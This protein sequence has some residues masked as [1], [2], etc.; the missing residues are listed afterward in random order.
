MN[1]LTSEQFSHQNITDIEQL[2]ISTQRVLSAK[3][4]YNTRRVSK[5]NITSLLTGSVIPK[6]G[7]LVLA[8]V[9][10]IGQHKR[11]ELTHGR[12]APLFVG[13]EII[14]CYG[15]RYAPDQFEAEIP[16]D[17][18]ACHLVAAGGVASR[19]I[20]RHSGIRPATVIQPLGLLGDPQGNVVN[21]AHCALKPITSNNSR[22]L[23]I[24]VVGTSMNAG[25]TTSAAYLIKGLSNAGMRVGAAKLTGTGAGG[26]RWLMTDAGA[27]SVYDFTDA[28]HVSTYR[29]ASDELEEVSERLINQLMHDG[30]QAIVLEIADGLLQKETASLLC[31]SKFRSLI[32]GVLFA[33][34]DAMGADNGVNWLRERG[35]PILALTGCLSSSPLA[36][37]EAQTATGLPVF[38]LDRLAHPD[39][40]TE[41]FEYAASY[42]ADELHT[43][44]Q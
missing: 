42:V 21:M 16:Q 44:A 30:A 29:V 17:L 9:E 2:P 36:A 37:R 15:D 25:K 28:G 19:C 20:S 43:S 31:S 12:R 5:A 40:A 13:D 3:A 22:P 38:G 32:D 39:V 10:T 11:I 34:G 27:H 7:D 24:T 35:L 1:T 14:V 6:S 26:D 23:V 8:R 33:A 18:D 4:A 41:L